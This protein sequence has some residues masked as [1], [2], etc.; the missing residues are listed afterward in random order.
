MR[1]L[2]IILF[3]IHLIPSYAQKTM[4]AEEYAEKYAPLAIKDMQKFKIPASITLA[5]GILESSC[6]ASRLAIEGN[7]H[8]GI[9]CKK[10]WKGATIIHDDDEIGECFRKYS[11]VEDSYQ[12]HS[13][14]LSTRERY[15]SL[16]Q[17]DIYDYKAW[18]HGL[19]AAGYATNPVYAENLIR[20]IEN[21]RLYEYDRESAIKS[22]PGKEDTDKGKHLSSE[23]AEK[24]KET[25]VIDTPAAI[26]SGTINGTEY[27]IAHTGDSFTTISFKTDIPVKKLLSYN[28]L[29]YETTIY[30]G[31]IVFLGKK[32]NYSSTNTIHVVNTKSNLYAISQLF[33]VSLKS[34]EKMNPDFISGTIPIGAEIR[35]R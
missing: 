19:K 16:F 4:T 15:A 21:N 10:D 35:L 27:I 13:L 32:K 2:L 14:F 24:E 1:K 18:A 22:N 7:N 8:F 28:D 3:A 11:S 34:L 6:G 20:I 9:K 12:D 29:Q 23:K 26:E 31:T 25:I 5:Q 30:D 33:G 17:L